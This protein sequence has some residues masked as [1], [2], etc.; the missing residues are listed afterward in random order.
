MKL[1]IIKFIYLNVLILIYFYMFFLKK[2]ILGGNKITFYSF[3]NEEPPAH[4]KHR[5]TKGKPLRQLSLSKRALINAANLLPATCFDISRDS[6][7]A[8]VACARSV[9]IW[10]INTP[11]LQTTFD[12]HTGL[13]TCV[14]FAPNSEFVASGSEDKTVIIWGLAL[15]LIATTF[16][17]IYISL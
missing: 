17:V 3:R 9:Q 8:A 7:L 2:N 15:G 1:I 5:Y 4:I 16:K 10:Q 11:Q 14:S 13:V 12:G 6:Q